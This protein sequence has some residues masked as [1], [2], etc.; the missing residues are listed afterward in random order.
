MVD[1]NAHFIHLPEDECRALLATQTVGR[2]AFVDGD[3]QQLVPVNFAVHEGDVVFRTMAG[4]VLAALADGHDAVAFGV[5]HH[6]DTY[7]KGWS[8]TVVGSTR[9]AD[10]QTVDALAGRRPRPWAP[11]ERDLL[12]RLHPHTIE[13]RKVRQH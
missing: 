6:D 10:E 11:G 5:D 2:L 12:V 1:A 3:G 9:V 7:Q 8:V 13:G 4:T